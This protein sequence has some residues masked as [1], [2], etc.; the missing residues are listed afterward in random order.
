MGCA[1]EPSVCALTVHILVCWGS[2]RGGGHGC[3]ACVWSHVAGQPYCICPPSTSCLLW[4]RAKNRVVGW[5]LETIVCACVCCVCV[6]VCVCV[7]ACVRACVR[8]H[9]SYIYKAYVCIHFS[10]LY[11]E[12]SSKGSKFKV[13]RG[14]AWLD[15]NGVQ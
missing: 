7:R 3:T 8:V 4:R 15:A 14:Q 12:V 6:C 10:V 5:L 2:F 9:I 1:W 11:L 13:S